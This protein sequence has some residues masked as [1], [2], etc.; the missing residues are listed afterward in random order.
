MVIITKLTDILYKRQKVVEMI[1]I[2][3]FCT[4]IIFRFDDT[5]AKL[6]WSNYPFLAVILALLTAI[7]VLV[8]LRI[9]KQKTKVIIRDLQ[10]S[11]H[12]E[13]S[14]ARSQLATLSAR[15]R[16]VFDLILQGKSNK[17][18]TAMLY[19]EQSTLKT[20]INQIYKILEIKN[21]RETKNFVKTTRPTE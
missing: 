5:T 17:E 14:H 10:N 1:A 3:L 20:H 15:Q 21:R 12:E 13:S 2:F 16:E 19:I 4:L 8:W 7:S 6:L 18:I 11:G 9:E